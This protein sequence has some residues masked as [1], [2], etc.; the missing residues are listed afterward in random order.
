[1]KYLVVIIIVLLAG[2]AT[3]DTSP[4]EQELADAYYNLGN[5]H[6][7]LG[8]H[9]RA[10]RAYQRSLEVMPAHYEASWNLASAWIAQSSYRNA[11]RQIESLLE[12]DPEHTQLLSTA[13]W[14]NLQLG[15]AETALALYQQARQADPGDPK[16]REG[17]IK[18]LMDLGRFDQARS[19]ALALVEYGGVKKT[20]LML[21]YEI[22][23]KL[24]R[25]TS[26]EWL[27]EA[28]RRFPGDVEIAE[29]LFLHYAEAGRAS[30]AAEVLARL[31]DQ[32]KLPEAVRFFDG[33]AD[34]QLEEQ[35]QE[36]LPEEKRSALLDAF[37]Q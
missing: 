3:G 32:G 29:P 31:I 7:R 34:E 16:I 20:P 27:Q 23:L 4:R 21:L 10:V 26:S 5:A 36:A 12:A 8:E 37:T 15:K 14:L 1:M 24:E 17:I 6:M 19:E 9:S 25:D 11:L 33:L 30:P 18:V 2:C 28:W 22:D 35:I 13:A